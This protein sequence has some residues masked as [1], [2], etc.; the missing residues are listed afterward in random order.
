M[1]TCTCRLAR[2]MTARRKPPSRRVMK[3][4]F[5]SIRGNARRDVIA[6]FEGNAL[7]VTAT[8][9]AAV[10]LRATAPVRVKYREA[11]S[12][13]KNGSVLMPPPGLM[14]WTPEPSALTVKICE[15]PSLESTTASLP[16]S[17]DQAGAEFRPL[18]LATTLRCPLASEWT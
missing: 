13:E 18:K 17:G 5:F 11:P 9:A 6:A 4:M 14:R 2:S 10:D 8:H 3:A 16:P 7:D 12:G 1:S 15:P